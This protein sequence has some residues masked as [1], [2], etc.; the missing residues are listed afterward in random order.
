[1]MLHLQVKCK[2]PDLKNN[3][4]FDT[5]Y[6]E[7]L[8]C[9]SGCQT[10][11]FH[12]SITPLHPSPTHSPSCLTLDWTLTRTPPQRLPARHPSPHSPHCFW[13]ME[14]PWYIFR[15][16]EHRIQTQS[17]LSLS[18]ALFPPCRRPKPAIRSHA[19]CSLSSRGAQLFAGGHTCW[20]PNEWLAFWWPPRMAA[21]RRDGRLF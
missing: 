3:E 11:N 5:S 21:D 7:N 9:C 18:L 2:H 14:S 1:M 4:T 12:P 20:G 16:A 6:T 17:P 8:P 19:M 15:A 10:I 13:T